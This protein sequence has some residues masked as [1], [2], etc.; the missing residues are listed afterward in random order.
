MSLFV[1]FDLHFVK[2]ALC[3]RL[4][5]RAPPGLAIVSIFNTLY[6]PIILS[7]DTKK[8]LVSLVRIP[9][10]YFHTTYHTYFFSGRPRLVE[11]AHGDFEAEA[12]CAQH[13][14][15]AEQKAEG[16]MKLTHKITVFLV[17]CHTQKKKRKNTIVFPNA[18]IQ[19]HN[20]LI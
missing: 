15:V 17:Y 4:H 6:N 14:L 10:C 20:L 19:T 5:F 11:G 9:Y 8:S 12:V 2:T 1:F 13:V 3:S 18:L 16:S 7:Q